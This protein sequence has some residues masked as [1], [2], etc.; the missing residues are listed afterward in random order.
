MMWSN[1]HYAE[2]LSTKENQMNK[3]MKLS[4]QK[5][6]LNWLKTLII[7]STSA[8]AEKSDWIE[9]FEWFDINRM[10]AIMK[11]KSEPRNN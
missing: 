2:L 5:I 7:K 3:K 10:E 8:D 9:S 4:E 11:L 1:H 6:R